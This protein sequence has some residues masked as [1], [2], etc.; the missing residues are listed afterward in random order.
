MRR[1]VQTFSKPKDIKPPKSKRR[2]EHG[3]DDCKVH[4]EPY[5]KFR[6][7]PNHV[8][9]PEEFDMMVN[10]PDDYDLRNWEEDRQKQ[11]LAY[12]YHSCIKWHLKTHFRARL[13][14]T[15]HPHKGDSFTHVYAFPL[16]SMVS[17]Y[18]ARLVIRRSF[19]LDLLE[20][21]SKNRL[22]S[23][24]IEEIKS[25]RIAIARHQ[26][27]IG[28]SLST[29]KGLVSLEKGLDPMKCEIPGW[30]GGGS[31]LV[32]NGDDDSWQRI[33]GDFGELKSSMDALEIRANKIQEGTMG[34]LNV[35]QKEK[36]EVSSRAS[37]RLNVGGAIFAIVLLPFSIIPQFFQM[38]HDESKTGLPGSK[39]IMSGKRYALYNFYGVLA[40]I[41]MWL[42]CIVMYKVLWE[43]FDSLKDDFRYHYNR[44]ERGG[45]FRE[46]KLRA[47]EKVKEKEKDAPNNGHIGLIHHK[48]RQLD[49]GE[50]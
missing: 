25:R 28:S 36:A 49:E 4:N 30:V 7:I 16:Y 24:M 10:D 50:A 21:R 23:T 32:Q 20:W 12:V 46:R 17:A 44:R 11:S 33:L 19:D 45:Y 9:T 2:A 22:N 14:K 5:L 18:W 35:V 6:S 42:L 29:L 1:T 43:G 41:C 15:S 3:M 48:R 31:G 26:R 13:D 47:D 27:N 8:P 39:Q 40:F 38:T 34:L 37:S